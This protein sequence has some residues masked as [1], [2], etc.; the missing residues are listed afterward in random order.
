MPVETLDAA[1]AALFGIVS[2]IMVKSNTW[3]MGPA[4]R[5]RHHSRAGEWV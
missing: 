2:I 5:G 3:R 4:V 1:E